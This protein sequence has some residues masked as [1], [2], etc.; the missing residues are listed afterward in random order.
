MKYAAAFMFLL[1]APMLG[2]TQNLGMAI[3]VADGN[4]YGKTRPRIVVDANGTPIILWGRK[5]TDK[6]YV[7]R[8]DGNV[9]TTP[10]QVTPGTLEGFVSDWAGPDMVSNGD[11]VFVTFH[12]Q[13]ESTGY[14]YV[15]KSSDGGVTFGDTVRAENA[16]VEQ[17]RFPV[18]AVDPNG[19]PA[20]MFMKFEGN[21]IDPQYVVA[22]SP[23]GGLSYLDDVN[24]SEIAPGEVCDCC[25]AAL[26]SEGQRQIA[27]FRNNDNN[28][29]DL[30]VTISSDNGADFDTGDDMDPNNWMINSCPS[31]GPDGYINGDS[32]YTVWMSAGLGASRIFMSSVHLPS[33]TRGTT[34]EVSPNQNS[35]ANQNYGRIAGNGEVMGIVYQEA[36]SGNIDCFITI[37]MDGGNT[38]SSP[39]LLH[40]E[41][42]GTQRNPDVTY[43]NG[44]FHV[45]FEDVSAGSVIYRS[46]SLPGVGI[47]ENDLNAT[48]YLVSDRTINIKFADSGTWEVDIINGLGQLV[49][50]N[51]V[52]KNRLDVTVANPGVYVVS[53]RQDGKSMTKQLM[54]K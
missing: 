12:S 41:V 35:S 43:Y 33:A 21:W 5:T 45:A 17:S 48:I 34:W 28:L 22:N 19:N 10:I 27:M 23:N 25:P 18:I 32:L 2:L 31:T 14:V 54:V 42:N 44:E 38:F 4:T 52:T 24:A 8:L 51:T 53:V 29:R 36:A 49:Y 37:S 7:A 30:W 11:D 3:P 47:E 16:A 20:V 9:F 39:I 15:V 6:V 26:L 40:D 13:P 46:V 1:I 50:Q